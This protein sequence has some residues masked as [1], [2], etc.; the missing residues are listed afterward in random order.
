[1]SNS[2]ISFD[3]VAK[4]GGFNQSAPINSNPPSATDLGSGVSSRQPMPA[5]PSN[6]GVGGGPSWD[7]SKTNGDWSK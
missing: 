7:S 5:A 3:D 2:S 4:G 1:M 6:P